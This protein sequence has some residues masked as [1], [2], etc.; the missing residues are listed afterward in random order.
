M[1]KGAV[2]LLLC[3]FACG[4]CITAP[5]PKADVHVP[6]DR[7]ATAGGL[8]SHEIMAVIR[9]HLNEIRHCYE[10]LLKRTPDAAGKLVVQF[11][12]GVAGAVDRAIV[13]G[14]TIE[15]AVMRGCV[16]GKVKGWTFPKPRGAQAV[17]VNYPFV[18][19]PL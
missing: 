14:S 18:F 12:V 1:V 11:Q 8:T 5:A 13:T 16:I 9:A 4:G 2:S 19:N 17:T 6:T 10:A 7:P 3:G 15:D